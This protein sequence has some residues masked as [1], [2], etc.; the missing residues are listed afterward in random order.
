M[1]LTKV[2]G[3]E[4]NVLVYKELVEHRPICS[5]MELATTKKIW[6]APAFLPKRERPALGYLLLPLMGCTGNQGLYGTPFGAV[7]QSSL[8][9]SLPIHGR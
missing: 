3:R 8:R 4:G 7:I 2:S 5:P 6:V 1:N 9:T